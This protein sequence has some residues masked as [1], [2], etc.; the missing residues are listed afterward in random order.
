MNALSNAWT[1][2]YLKVNGNPFLVVGAEVHNSSSSS[3]PAIIES[4]DAV[5]RLG[6]NTVLAPVAWE[7]F[8]PEEGHFDHTLINVM[9]E[10]ARDR[11]LRLI[12]LWFGT[13]KNAASTYV[14]AWM[15]RA[16]DRFPRSVLSDSR[17]AAQLTPFSPATQASDARAFAAL[18]AHIREVD[19]GG[20]VIA[21]QVQNEIGLLGD[22]RDRSVL[23]E[24]AFS[25]PVP[26]AVLEAIQAEPDMP[27]HAEW[28]NHGRIEAGDWSTVFPAGDRTDEAFMAAAYARYTEQVAAA[29]R[30]AHDVPLFVNAW[31]DADSV[32][33]GP[34]A[35][36]GGKR[37]GDYPSG[38]PVTPVAAIWEAMAPSL[39]L[40]AVDAYVDDA[41]PVFARF[42]ARRGRLLVP[43]LRADEAGIAQMFLAIGEHRATGVSPF[44]VD[45]LHEHDPGAAEL[46]DAFKL[47][48]AAAGII[49]RQPDA[50]MTG[51][52]L[53]EHYSRHR[54]E[55]GE[56]TVQL[57]AGE[58]GRGGYGLTIA[59][60]ESG[61]FVI[62]RG[63]SLTL[64]AQPGRQASFTAA[65]MF[66]L[67]GHKLA[68]VQ[69]L[70]GDET[71]SGTRIEF[72]FG[73]RGLIPGRPIPTRVPD[74]GIVRVEMY[75]Y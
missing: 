61:L 12:P 48:Q 32:L 38:G 45:A 27:L 42:A 49:A 63:F 19:T 10:G 70:N 67:D 72:P 11:G 65:T 74:S 9:I 25:T 24:A 43:E 60:G 47:L 69:Q 64:D 36:A 4:F 44:G 73:G 33:D 55:I 17:P 5:Q 54:V 46:S 20:T 34:I 21:V 52:V 68:V 57:D 31:L 75:T 56:V 3:A 22:T 6:A 2:P 28:V 41:D 16:P 7:L 8:E 14:P 29:G 53:D 15:K 66:E 59:D 40:L 51:F 58:S 37:P 13:W 71:A 18:M 39:D 35:V 26:P 30:A 62:G 50:A 23:A 1:G